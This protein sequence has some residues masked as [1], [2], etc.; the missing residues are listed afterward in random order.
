MMWRLIRNGGILAVL[1]ALIWIAIP[2]ENRLE[3]V[4]KREQKA[5]IYEKRYNKTIALKIAAAG[6]G[7]NKRERKCL[8]Y[9]WSSESRFDNY[10]RP[11]DRKGKATSTAFGIAQLLGERSSDPIVQIA[12]GLR[13][14]QY[15]Y[16]SAC[17]AWEFHKRRGWY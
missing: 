8:V 13:Y 17:R 14:I 5:T 12:G 1:L 6:F 10:A 2:L 7:Y 9:L 11:T 4:P 16:K 3:K 15:R